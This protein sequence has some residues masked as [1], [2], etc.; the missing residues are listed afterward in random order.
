[1]PCLLVRHRAKDYARWER[2]FHKH[3]A[4]R[5]S[6]GSKGGKLGYISLSDSGEADSCSWYS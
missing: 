6:N 3:G 4:V 1:M 2:E 5:K